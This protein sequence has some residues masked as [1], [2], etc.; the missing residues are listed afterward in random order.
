MGPQE[1]ARYHGDPTFVKSEGTDAH[2]AFE[3]SARC[4]NLGTENL[5]SWPGLPRRCAHSLRWSYLSWKCSWVPALTRW[6]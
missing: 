5:V 4:E 6:V 2:R 1:V 3:P